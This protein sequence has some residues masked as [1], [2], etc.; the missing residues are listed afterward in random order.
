MQLKR[1]PGLL[2]IYNKC[3][4]DGQRKWTWAVEWS[5]V[6]EDDECNGIEFPPRQYHRMCLYLMHVL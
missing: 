3:V 1:V 2:F 4:V 6:V 5:E